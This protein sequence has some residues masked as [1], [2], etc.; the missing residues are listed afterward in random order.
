MATKKSSSKQSKLNAP[1]KRVLGKE[2]KKMHGLFT[3]SPCESALVQA[4]GNPLAMQV[5]AES[6]YTQIRVTVFPTEE[7]YFC[8]SKQQAL[9]YLAV[10]EFDRCRIELVT[11]NRDLRY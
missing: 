3:T 10:K 4:P 9:A 1:A 11:L 8:Y 6:Q 2:P 7:Q 5:K